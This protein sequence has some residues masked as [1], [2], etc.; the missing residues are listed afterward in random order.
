MK[1][2]AKQKTFQPKPT[3]LSNCNINAKIKQNRLKTKKYYTP[4]YIKW[5][6][7]YTD[8]NGTWFC[9]WINERKRVIIIKQQNIYK[10]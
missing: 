8:T 6:I 9:E 5:Q 7:W 3:E 10:Y 4:S 1:I 2:Q